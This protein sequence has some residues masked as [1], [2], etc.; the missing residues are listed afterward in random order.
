MI[1]KWQVVYFTDENGNSPVKEFLNNL[2]ESQQG[3]VGRI[4]LYIEEYGLQ[5]II[6]HTKKLSGTPF[7]EIRILGKDNI[8]VIYIIPTQYHV[9]ALHGF[10]KKTQKTP[11]KDMQIS[12]KRYESWKKT[13]K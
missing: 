3:K 11:L 6:P 12:L 5:S 8:R 10:I 1:A 2:T 13:R 4:I 7:W 9:L